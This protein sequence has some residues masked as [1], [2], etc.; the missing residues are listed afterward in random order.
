L[1]NGLSHDNGGNGGNDLNS[2]MFHGGRL[3]SGLP[4]VSS[5]SSTDPVYKGNGSTGQ[6]HGGAPGSGSVGASWGSLNGLQNGLS[7]P[8]GNSEANKQTPAPQSHG[9][10]REG[11]AGVSG[12]QVPNMTIEQFLQRNGLSHYLP[13]FQ[14]EEIDLNTLF[15]LKPA[16]LAAMGIKMGPRLKILH[17]I[18]ELRGE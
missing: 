15:L 10:E 18:E 14:K 16:H 9:Q 1:Q 5:L 12:G 17:A 4:G 8:T 2:S 6:S 3:P 11:S 13:M 7:A